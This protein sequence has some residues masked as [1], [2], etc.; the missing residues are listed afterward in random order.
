MKLETIADRTSDFARLQ[1]RDAATWEALFDRMYPRMLAYAERRVGSREDARDAVSESFAR[2]VK[3]VD[4]LAKPGATPDGWCFGI[5]HHVVA[6]AQ[7][8]MYR[9]PSGSPVDVRVEGEV[10]DSLVLADEHAAVRDAFAELSPKD[11]DVLELRVVAGLQAEE[12]AQILSMRPGAVRMAQVRA[13]DRLRAGI[14]KKS[15]KQ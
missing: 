13:L 10:G 7:R 9:R 3:S 4:G 14:T 1:A 5:L 2:L 12:V 15:S 11:R 8:R 6:D